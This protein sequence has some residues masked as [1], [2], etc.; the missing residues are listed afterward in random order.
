M[1]EKKVTKEVKVALEL[2]GYSPK[3]IKVIQY[4]HFPH[5][6]IV[7]MNGEHFGTY[8]TMKKTFVD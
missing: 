8:D 3:S 1:P 6:Y 7:I 2:L 5:L 4:E